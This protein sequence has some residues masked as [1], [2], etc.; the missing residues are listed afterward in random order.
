MTRVRNGDP[1][2]MTLRAGACGHYLTEERPLHVL[3]V[4]AST[5]HVARHGLSAW[6]SAGTF[7]DGAAYG[8]VE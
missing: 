2:A 4:A 7:A 5:T 6:L 3:D 1:E 8:G